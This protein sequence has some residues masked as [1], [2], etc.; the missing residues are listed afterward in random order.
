MVCPIKIRRFYR[1]AA[2][3]RLRG[4]NKRSHERLAASLQKPCPE[5]S[6]ALFKRLRAVSRG[7]WVG[8]KIIYSVY[9]LDCSDARSSTVPALRPDRSWAVGY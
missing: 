2:L 4:G 8:V 9:Q 5:R 6:K 1:S 3:T 7:G